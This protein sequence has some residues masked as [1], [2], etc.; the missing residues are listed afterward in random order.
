[1]ILRGV[2]APRRWPIFEDFLGGKLMFLRNLKIPFWALK[3]LDFEIFPSKI[4][5]GPIKHHVNCKEE[6]TLDE[7]NTA[8]GAFGAPLGQRECMVFRV[9]GSVF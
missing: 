3:P 6:D 8:A 1:M 5:S 4:Y 9:F 2:R 7:S